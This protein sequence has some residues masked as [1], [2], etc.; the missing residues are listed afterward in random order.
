M[1]TRSSPAAT[2]LKLATNPEGQLSFDTKQLSAK[3]GSVT[4]TLTNAAP[5]EHN[6]AIAEG[7]KVLASTPTFAGGAKSVTVK[8]KPGKYTFYCTVPGHRQAGMEGTLN[9]S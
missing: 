1:S 4:I 6:V 5:V 7:S 8:L 3:A 9:V 2:A